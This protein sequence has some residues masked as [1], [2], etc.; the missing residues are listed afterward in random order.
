MTTKTTLI[1]FHA[2]Q[3]FEAH[4]AHG[5]GFR[6][7]LFCWGISSRRHKSLK[8]QMMANKKKPKETSDK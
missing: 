8:Q 5:K 6:F 2:L 3:P 4:F 7:L 1:T